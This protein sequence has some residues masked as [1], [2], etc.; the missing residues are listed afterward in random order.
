VGAVVSD[1][2]SSISSS[3]A[4]GAARARRRRAFLLTSLSPLGVGFDLLGKD[5]AVD[6][7]VGQH[8]GNGSDLLHGD[9]DDLLR[10]GG[11]RGVEGG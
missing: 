10:G 8:R 11:R 2:M 9:V 3:S 6:R 5:G 7:R 1:Y 4:G